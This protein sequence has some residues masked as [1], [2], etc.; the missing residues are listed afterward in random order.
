MK[1]IIRYLFF[2]LMLSMFFYACELD[3]YDYPDASITGRI[4]DSETNELVQSDLINGT[5]IK[6]IEHGYDPVSPQYLRVKS[7][8]TYANT[9]L[10]SNTYTIQPD[11]RN[12][13]QIDEQ[14]VEIGKNTTLDFIVTPY[15]RIN[16]ISFVNICKLIFILFC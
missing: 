2:P 12:F 10:F 15:L 3:N 16:N 5:T 1:T 11:L 9:L 6:L 8:G 4:I 7:D 14:E 13:V